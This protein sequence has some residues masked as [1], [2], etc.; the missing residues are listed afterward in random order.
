MKKKLGGI[1]D[2]VEIAM[3]M[4]DNHSQAVSEILEDIR[5]AVT[6]LEVSTGTAQPESAD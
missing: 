3:R 1:S 5:G 2:R 6:G 4:E